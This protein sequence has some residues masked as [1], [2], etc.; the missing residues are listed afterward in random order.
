M[1]QA[2][3]N[4]VTEAVLDNVGWDGVCYYFENEFLECLEAAKEEGRQEKENEAT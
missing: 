2:T 3:T 1:D 4:L